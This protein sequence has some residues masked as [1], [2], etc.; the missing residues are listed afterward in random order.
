[1]PAIELEVL[2]ILDCLKFSLDADLLPHLDNGPSDIIVAGEVPVRDGK[3]ELY[4]FVRRE[5]GFGEQFLG[6][7]DVIG[8]H[9]VLDVARGAWGR[10][11]G[12]RNSRSTIERLRK[13]GFVDGVVRGE[14]HIGI[15]EGKVVS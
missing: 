5:T 14:P 13:R 8:E 15:R 2:S 10:H 7:V 3:L 12:Q 6:L 4:R 1:M 11:N 9:E